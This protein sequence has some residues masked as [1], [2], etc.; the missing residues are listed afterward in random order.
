MS[1]DEV[2][3]DSRSDLRELARYGL[4]DI[5]ALQ[6][7]MPIIWRRGEERSDTRQAGERRST[8]PPLG[9]K[10]RVALTS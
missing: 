2:I 4:V 9:R 1:L 7:R 8:S 6:G 10:A 5:H 3:T